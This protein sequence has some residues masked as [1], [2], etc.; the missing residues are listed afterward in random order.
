MNTGLSISPELREEMLASPKGV[1]PSFDIIVGY[2]VK[3]LNAA[4]LR[5]RRI[6]SSHQKCLNNA[7]Q[8]EARNRKC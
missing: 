5:A 4:G 2:L 3:V 1:S 8:R 7:K 6:W